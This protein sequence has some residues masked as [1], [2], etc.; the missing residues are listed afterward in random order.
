[1]HLLKN[2]TN[3]VKKGKLIIEL[4]IKYRKNTHLGYI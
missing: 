4:R 3:D 1:M 2:F